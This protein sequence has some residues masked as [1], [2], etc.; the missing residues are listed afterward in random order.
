MKLIMAIGLV[1]G[2]VFASCLLWLSQTG[3]PPIG[4]IIGLIS[5][6]FVSGL[7]LGGDE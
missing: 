2:I 4:A 3:F 7:I 5:S 6:S 1:N